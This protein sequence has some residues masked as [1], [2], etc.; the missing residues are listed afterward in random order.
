MIGLGLAAAIHALLVGVNDN[1]ALVVSEAAVVEW[2]VDEVHAALR[3]VGGRK[4]RTLVA[5]PSLSASAW[6][7]A[8]CSRRIGRIPRFHPAAVV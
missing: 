5:I 1:V 3:F 8:A 4:S 7:V 2:M 6:S